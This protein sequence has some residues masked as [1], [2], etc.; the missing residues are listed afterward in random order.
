MCSSKFGKTHWKTH[1]P[2]T[3]LIKVF[4]SMILSILQMTQDKDK[5]VIMLFI[6]VLWQT[7]D[8][9]CQVMETLFPSLF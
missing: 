5:L 9:Y 6:I 8:F 4:L 3:S 2:E 1:V 7:Y